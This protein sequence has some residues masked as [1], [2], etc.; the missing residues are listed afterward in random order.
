VRMA[1][2]CKFCTRETPAQQHV[3]H[4]LRQAMMC[5]PLNHLNS[6]QELPAGSLLIHCVYCW[7]LIQQYNRGGDKSCGPSCH[8]CT[9][10][11]QQ[12]MASQDI[13]GQIKFAQVSLRHDHAH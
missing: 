1:N 5:S 4:G 13:M 11:N 8:N 9:W 12:R 3:F 6:L 2:I 7:T 10:S